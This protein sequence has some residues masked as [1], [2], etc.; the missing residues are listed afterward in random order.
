LGNYKVTNTIGGVVAVTAAVLSNGTNVL[1]T[2]A[3]R[4]A[5]ANYILIVNAVKDVSPRQNVIAT[6]SMIPIFRVVTLVQLT[7]QPED[8]KWRFYFGNNVLGTNWRA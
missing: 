5:N 8:H 7:T 6:N 4:D 2:T 1:L 3:A